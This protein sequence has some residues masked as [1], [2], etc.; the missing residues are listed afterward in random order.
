MKAPECIVVDFE[1]EPI[2]PRP[3]YPPKP[4]SLALQWPGS[5]KRLCMAWA[6][7]GGDNNCT[8]KEAYGELRRAY[9]SK[10]PLLFQN[11]AFDEDVAET[12]WELP[13]LPWERTH[14]TLYLIFMHDPHAATLS[15][16]PSAER[17]L[18]IKPEEQDRMYEWII[19]NVPEARRKPSEA[20]A[21][22]YKCPYKI[23]KPY[24]GGDLVRTSKMFNYLYPRI[25]AAGMLDAYNRER[26]LMPILLRNAQ[27]GMRLD[28]D[29]LSKDLPAMVKGR[30]LADDWVRK[31]LRSKELNLDSPAQLADALENNNVVTDF[32]LTAKG[33]RSTS[34][35]TLTLDKFKDPKVWQV[36]QY[37]GQ[38]DTCINMFAEPWLR[39][40]STGT[41][42]PTWSQVRSSKGDRDDTK[43]ARSGRIICGG[44][45]I[46]FLNIPKK[47]KRAISAGYVHPE[48]LGKA[49]VQLPYMRVY[50]L[51][52]RGHRWARRDFNQQELRLFAHFEE[53]P[54]MEGFLSDPNFDIHE[55]VRKEAEAALIKEALRDEFDR[56]SAKTSVF[57]RIYGQGIRGLME[58]MRLPESQRRVA[59]VIQASIN[60]AV[61]SIKQMDDALKELAAQGR[62]LRTWGGR[63]Y[64]CEPPAY[65]E[66]YGRDMT[67]EYKMLNYLI[68][69]SGADVTKEVIIRYENHPKKV[70]R[71][72]VTVYD[73]LNHSVPPGKAAMKQHM[74]VLGDVMLSIETDV[75]ML[76]DGEEGE[77]WGKLV[78]YA[79]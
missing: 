16:K 30:D 46:N 35:K 76:S 27:V 39:L 32:T 54:V 38:L 8:E 25:V 15:L 73:E 43:G 72:I 10:Y 1:T 52:D 3:A 28:V 45:G 24:H 9:R 61:P 40:G 33:K 50:C 4:V 2:R 60:R 78:K 7:E 74:T 64:Y 37:R 62:P 63:L 79:I 5:S 12:H 41:L 6:H 67:F 26:Q 20:G 18:G 70:A 21:Y 68:Q 44:G 59:Q 31:R 66:K 57:G 75:P 48:F 77:S 11:A 13:V 69:P 17:I 42:Y 14:D 29:Q 23:V 19:T 22:I 36:L 65:S 47:W 58:S 53:G 49:A 71:L 51:P 55:N 34:K 56:D